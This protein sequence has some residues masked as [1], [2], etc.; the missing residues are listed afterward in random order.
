MRYWDSSAIVP[1][2]IRESASGD[3]RALFG[4]DGN[5]LTSFITPIE[6]S[7]AVWRRLHRGEL[8][9]SGRAAADAQFAA[10]STNWS[11]SDKLQRI[12][13]VTLDH[14]LASAARAEGFPV[15]P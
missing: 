10:L 1:L 13:F 7:G 8:D 11:Q 5:I 2:L 14:D 15:L 12:T 4:E 9:A 3:M 6:V